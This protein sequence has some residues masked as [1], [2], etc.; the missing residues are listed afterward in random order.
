MTFPLPPQGWLLHCAPL[1]CNAY[2]SGTSSCVLVSL[3][4]I[5]HGCIGGDGPGL[6]CCQICSGLRDI[7]LL[8]L[9]AHLGPLVVNQRRCAKRISRGQHM[10]AWWQC[11]SS[12]PM[13]HC[14][15]FML[16]CL[17]IS[18]FFRISKHLGARIVWLCVRW[19]MF[20]VQFRQALEFFADSQ[21]YVLTSIS[22]KTVT[23]KLST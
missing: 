19:S 11:P 23:W 6:H 21:S 5:L 8:S 4:E 17:K 7:P 10:Q 1:N 15:L 14:S 22:L 16:L 2:A 13:V 3:R 18:C 12:G 20:F 9:L